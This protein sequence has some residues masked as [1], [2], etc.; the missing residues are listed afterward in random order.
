M[1]FGDHTA[2]GF[3]ANSLPPDFPEI[4]QQKV[5]ICLERA[6]IRKLS[7]LFALVFINLGDQRRLVRPP[8]IDSWLAGPRPTGDGLDTEPGIAAFL[9]DFD[10]GS[11]NGFMSMGTSQRADGAARGGTSHN[12]KSPGRALDKRNAGYRIPSNRNETVRFVSF[13]KES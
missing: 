10:G 6:E 7:D 9:K 3:A 4:S 1:R 11:E 5:E 12:K 13:L 8:A 2:K